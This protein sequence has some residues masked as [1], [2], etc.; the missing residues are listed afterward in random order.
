MTP[1][2]AILPTCAALAGEATRPLELQPP[3]PPPHASP[4]ADPY[5]AGQSYTS[6]HEQ[7]SSQKHPGLSPDPEAKVGALH[8]ASPSGT[9]QPQ[10]IASLLDS[11]PLCALGLHSD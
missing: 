7:M 10:W 3:A 4:P 8:T 2:E 5:V 11:L 9:K 6:H 1:C